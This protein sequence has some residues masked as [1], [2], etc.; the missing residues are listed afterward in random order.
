MWGEAE[1][2][3]FW[4]KKHLHFSVGAKLQLCSHCQETELITSQITVRLLPAAVVIEAWNSA[5]SLKNSVPGKEGWKTTETITLFELGLL[6]CN[7]LVLD[8]GA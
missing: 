1:A 3:T 6:E 8:F 5:P 7:T 4:T 2:H